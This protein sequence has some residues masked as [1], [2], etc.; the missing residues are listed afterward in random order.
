MVNCAYCKALSVRVPVL[1]LVF[2]SCP[3]LDNLLKYPVFQ[4]IDLSNEDNDNIYFIG[5]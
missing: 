1:H 3:N 4:F 2:S 5:L